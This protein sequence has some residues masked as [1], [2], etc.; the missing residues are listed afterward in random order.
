MS[1]RKSGRAVV[2]VLEKAEVEK[3]DEKG[4]LLLERE[5]PGSWRVVGRRR[6][7]F[8]LDMMMLSK[9]VMDVWTD[10]EEDDVGAGAVHSRSEMNSLKAERSND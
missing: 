3:R 10:V 8:R 1:E 4:F 9:S 7:R 5:S 2:L 6:P